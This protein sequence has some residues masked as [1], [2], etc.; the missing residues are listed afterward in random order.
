[1]PED[2]TSTAATTRELLNE[3]SEGDRALANASAT[4][5]DFMIGSTE[6]EVTGVTAAGEWVPVLR[7][8]DW[9]V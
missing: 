4:H 2:R 1:M 9:Q 3:L 7:G 5:V 6:L 8:D